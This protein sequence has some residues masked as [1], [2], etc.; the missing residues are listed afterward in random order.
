MPGPLSF[1]DSYSRT[2]ITEWLRRA[3]LG[4]VGVPRDYPDEGIRSAIVSA[5]PLLAPQSRRDLADAVR[6]LL[7]EITRGEHRSSDYVLT[8]TGLIVDFQLGDTITSLVELSKSF[9]EEKAKLSHAARNGILFAIIDLSIPQSDI[10]WTLYLGKKQTCFFSRRLG[11]IAFQFSIQSS[12]FPA[13]TSKL[14][15]FRRYRR[16]TTRLHRRYAE[17]R[18]PFRISPTG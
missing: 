6:T 8:L 4:K 12:R 13:A 17:S 16:L 14:C 15:R 3:L 18:R 10:F 2:Q 7:S 9:P 11:R 5:E 1:L